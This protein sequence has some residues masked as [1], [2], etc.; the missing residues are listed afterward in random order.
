MV[1]VKY[2]FVLKDLLRSSGLFK[3]FIRKIKRNERCKIYVYN[4]KDVR[5]L[6]GYIQAID[7]YLRMIEFIEDGDKT[8]YIN[9]RHLIDVEY[10]FVEKK[11]TK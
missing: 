3:H 5:V 10:P 6:S 4:G 1:Y 2:R 11:K 7:L 9:L 8:H